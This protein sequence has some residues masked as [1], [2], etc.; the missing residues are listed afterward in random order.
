MDWYSPH[1]Q[2]L[3][4]LC[5]FSP[6]PRRERGAHLAQSTIFPTS[7]QSILW[8]GRPRTL[9]ICLKSLHAARTNWS[10]QRNSTV[11]ISALTDTIFKAFLTQLCD[12]RE[13]R[14]IS[15]IHNQKLVFC[16]TSSFCVS[17]LWDA[18]I[19]ISAKTSSTFESLFYFISPT[20]K[21]KKNK[22]SSLSVFSRRLS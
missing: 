8:H 22:E 1:I 13:D 9:Q 17:A 11:N 4:T 15:K 12:F 6:M 14:P 7:H 21:M 2:H 20:T 18:I 5:G 19:Q 3:L 16:S 10:L